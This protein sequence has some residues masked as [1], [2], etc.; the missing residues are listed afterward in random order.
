[1]RP[2]LALLFS[3]IANAALAQNPTCPTRLVGDATNAC[4][5]TAFVQ[6]QLAASAVLSVVNSDGTLTIAP[7][8]GSVVASLNLAHVNTWTALQTL[9]GG[10]TSA[11]NPL[12]TGTPTG[13]VTSTLSTEIIQ[14]NAASLNGREFL[15]SLGLTSATGSG[16]TAGNDKVTLYSGAVGN[17]GTSNLWSLN[18]L[19]TLSASSGSYTGQGYE[20]DVNNLNADRGAAD[21]AAGLTA[22]SVYGINI[23]GASTF[24]STAAALI[25]GATDQWHRGVTIANNSVKDSAFADYGHSTISLDV[26]GTH[27]YGLDTQ[28]GTFTVPIRLGFGSALFWRNNGNTSDVAVLSLTQSTTEAVAANFYNQSTASNTTKTAA[29]NF[30]GY[31]TVSSDKIASQIVAM[32]VDANWVA[33]N[34]QFR[35]RASDTV[36]P[37]L[38]LNSAQHVAYSA[39][40][41]PTASACAGFALGTGSTDTAGHV[42]F[43]SST[44]CAIAFGTAFANAPLCTASGATAGAGTATTTGVLTMTFGAAQTAASWICYGA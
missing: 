21:G 17:S 12:V 2:F 28:N 8:T 31:D 20:L 37:A 44:T 4:A 29:I 23:T 34:L 9:N 41:L 36:T 40:V 39:A 13:N 25:S 43:T 16:G 27:T 19:I 3:L 38:T 33:A 5:S 7:T 35:T 15:V 1:M 14:G 24:P 18:T 6:N 10:I 30:R 22:P 11:A 42:T 26:R 32:P